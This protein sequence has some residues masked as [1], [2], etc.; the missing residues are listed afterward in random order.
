MK[1]MKQVFA[2]ALLCGAVAGASASDTALFDL[3][4]GTLSMPVLQ[5][6]AGAS[7]RDVV[8]RL[9]DPGQLRM[10]DPA[11]GAGIQFVTSGNVL[12]LPKVV[13]GG[14]TYPQVSLVNPSLVLVSVGELVVDSGVGGQ[15]QLDIRVSAAGV[16]VPPITVANV[17]KPSSQADF[18]ND[19][20]LR[21]TITQSAGGMVGSWTMT[22]CSFNG[23][24][25]QIDMVLNAGFVSLPYSATYTYR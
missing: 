16:S 6:D 8:I 11:V 10:N 22:G 23:S 25:G 18:C 2:A 17:P 9:L 1:Q 15:Y 13:A 7:Y 21:D 14:V 20:G 5:L 4:T 19:P 3:A 12:R 24:S